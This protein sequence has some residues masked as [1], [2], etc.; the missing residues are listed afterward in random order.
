MKTIS[1]IIFLLYPI[2]SVPFFIIG[3]LNRQRWAFI[4]CALFMGLLAI[5]YPP[6]GDLYRY[7]EDFNLYKDCDWSTFTILLV[8]KFDYFLPFISFCIGKLGG[9]VELTRFIFT[10][11]SYYL[12]FDLFLLIV[13]DNKS[14]LERNIYICALIILVPLTFWT[15][16]FRYFFAAAFLLNGTYRWFF[17]NEKKGLFLIGFSILVH[18][19]YIPFI[20][21]CWFAK[22]RFFKFH[23]IIVIILFALAFILD[24]ASLGEKLLTILPFS[25]SL[26]EHIFE[27]IDGSQSEDTTKNFSLL[28]MLVFYISNFVSFYIYYVYIRIYRLNYNIYMNLVNLML[29]M[30]LVTASFPVIFGRLT[31]INL[32]LI[33]ISM[34][35][36]YLKTG[37]LTRYFKYMCY[38]TIF[39]FAISCWQKRF[40]LSVS[41]ESKIF[42]STLYDILTFSYSEDWVNSN[43]DEEG[44]FY[45]RL[46]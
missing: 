45:K 36:S 24:T 1:I 42:T 17:Y 4:L 23:Y 37:K 14:L 21:L 13:K 33:K 11:L 8:F 28:Q 43:L 3:I 22:S 7:A 2:L 5:L 31:L 41:F 35:I 38:A 27:Y 19:S 16:L 40:F 39:L 20:F 26:V 32:F 29:I 44:D 12:L 10:F 18:V 6:A 15:F 9:T 30:L 46:G 34:L 25:D